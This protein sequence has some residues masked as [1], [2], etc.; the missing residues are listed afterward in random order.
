VKHEDESDST[1][2]YVESC[3]MLRPEREHRPFY[4]CP[5]PGSLKVLSWCISSL[6]ELHI[7][8]HAPPPALGD[9]SLDFV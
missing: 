4:S 6:M 8:Q 5:V 9:F 3:A 1:I 2:N 7:G